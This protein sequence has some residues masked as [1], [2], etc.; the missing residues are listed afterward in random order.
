MEILNEKV[1][2]IIWN[3]NNEHDTDPFA[4]RKLLELWE[5]WIFALL[6]FALIFIQAD[7]L[8]IATE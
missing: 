4:F 6:C 5:F 2:Q 7:G 1:S 3:I 8:T